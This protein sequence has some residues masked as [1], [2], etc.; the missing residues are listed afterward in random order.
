MAMALCDT[1]GVDRVALLRELWHAACLSMG[2]G[3]KRWRCR[4][5]LRDL[6]QNGYAERVCGISLKVQVFD[7]ALV[8]SSNFDAMYGT[9]RMQEVV[10]LLKAPGGAAR[11]TPAAAS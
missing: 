6:A 7:G 9:G 5:A 1:N 2:V 11:T 10:N 8:D 3:R 4:R